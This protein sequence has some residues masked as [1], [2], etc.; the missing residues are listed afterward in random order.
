MSGAKATA[1]I[2]MRAT[3]AQL[4]AID[5]RAGMAGLTR[6]RYM[7][8][9]ALSCQ[10][11]VT[12]FDPAPVREANRLLAN[13]TGNLN[14]MARSINAHGFGDGDLVAIVDAMEELEA[15]VGE[16]RGALNDMI[17]R[18]GRIDDHGVVHAR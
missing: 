12:T 7:I 6:S 9:S 10:L 15:G 13:A 1:R 14:Q 2:H 16:V 8:E 17:G 11:A 18:E 3:P 5:R 4:A